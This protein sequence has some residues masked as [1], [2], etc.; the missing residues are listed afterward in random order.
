MLQDISEFS[1]L[2]NF[3]P[4]TDNRLATLIVSKMFIHAFLPEYDA[5]NQELTE[6]LGTLCRL[7]I[8]VC[9]CV[10]D[11]FHQLGFGEGA[12]Q[13]HDQSGHWIRVAG[14]IADTS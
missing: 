5:D 1:R 7:C 13:Q 8:Q 2:A 9:V 12:H 14:A 3:S 11:V 10:F 4:K 6:T